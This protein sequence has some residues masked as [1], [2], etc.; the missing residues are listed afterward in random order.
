[1]LTK[2]KN[3]KRA[4]KLAESVSRWIRDPQVSG[5]EVGWVEEPRAYV[6]P[7]RQVAGRKPKADG[8]WHYD[9]WVC[10]LPAE[11]LFQLCDEDLPPSASAEAVALALLYA[12]D[13][14]GGG[15]ETQNKADKQGLGLGRRRKQCL[16][17]QEM[18]VSLGQLAHHLLIWARDRQ[19]GIEPRLR[20]Y[21]IMRLERDV[22]QISGC[23]RL[24]AQGE[25]RQVILNER[26][27][28]A[29]ICARAFT[30]DDLSLI[31][32]QT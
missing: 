6:R 21:G 29:S 30:G 10:H 19:A 14:R 17:A 15:L 27:P 13:R 24:G 12:Y 25:M 31:L 9:V 18:V 3:W 20:R 4:R 16:A 26:H 22:L 11:V 5:R 23:I 1:M 2:V 28:L 8:S 32:G 7:T